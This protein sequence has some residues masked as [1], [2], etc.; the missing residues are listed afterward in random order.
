MYHSLFIQ[1]SMGGIG[2]GHLVRE[3][4]ALGGLI[5]KVSDYSGIHFHVLNQSKGPAVH[6]PRAQIDRQL[7]S[8]YMQKEMKNVQNLEIKES[9]V[10]DI[11]YDN[12]NNQINGVITDKGV[13]ITSKCVVITTGTFLGANVHIGKK[14]YPAGRHLRDSEEVEPP[15][16]NLS[17]SIAK[18]KIPMCNYLLILNN[19]KRDLQQEHRQGFHLKA[20]IPKI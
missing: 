12:T 9:S 19:K 3:I 6:G 10:E 7:Y 4:D 16:I 2:K 15:S 8:K 5:G 18:L 13:K 17:K 11:I 20:L 14:K 1:P